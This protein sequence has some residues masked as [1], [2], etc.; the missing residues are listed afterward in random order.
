MIT[1]A[2]WFVRPQCALHHCSPLH[3]LEA[4][5]ELVVDARAVNTARQ[6]Y[7]AP[8]PGAPCLRNVQP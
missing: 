7:S 6:A 5:P 2:A 1:I 8:E 3:L 4:E